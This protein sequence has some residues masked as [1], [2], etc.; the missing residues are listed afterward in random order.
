VLVLRNAELDS[1]E[2]ASRPSLRV[3]VVDGQ[4]LFQAALGGLLAGP[5]LLASVRSCHRSDQALEWA[6]AEHFDL[7]FCDVR[8]EPMS[9]PLL[10]KRL[11][12]ATHP[13]RTVLLADAAEERLLMSTL[14]CG[15]AGFFT[16]DSSVE[17]F[18]AG[19][20]AIWRGHYVLCSRLAEPALALLSSA[21]GPRDG[22]SQLSPA[23]RH[24]LARIGR[25]ESVAAI[26][27]SKGISQKTVRNHLASIYR[28][29]DLRSRT[30]A[31]LCA[32]RLGLTME[33]AF[34]D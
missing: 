6:L 29:L 26:A 18:M 22:I 3:L 34:Q 30:E 31:I 12:G 27:R 24:I 10:A 33:S 9:G 23:E 5:P 16:K 13:V 7:V 28:K 21:A 32:A 8:A 1:A 17:E 11:A 25:A 19:V 14:D 4:A 2:L 20:E 15:A